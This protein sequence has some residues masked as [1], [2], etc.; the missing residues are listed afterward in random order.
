[1]KATLVYNTN[2]EPRI[3]LELESA[4]E[5]AKMAFEPDL[6]LA[7]I[8]E[9]TGGPTRLSYAICP[10]NAREKYQYGD[11]QP[12]SPAERRNPAYSMGP[13]KSEADY[14]KF[15]AR[16]EA[17]VEEA[18]DECLKR[19]ERIA[20]LDKD[21]EYLH[22]EYGRLKLQYFAETAKPRKDT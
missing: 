2:E 15:I 1:M 11:S 19:D 20:K 5:G 13:G 21:I 6:L 8:E 14:Q 18:L 7:M 16:Y 3:L 22:A 9:S 10:T 17:T 12:L 4:E